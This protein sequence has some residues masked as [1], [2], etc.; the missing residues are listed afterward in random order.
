LEFG[1]GIRD[2]KCLDDGATRCR[3]SFKIGL[4]VLIQYRPWRTDGQTDGR[5]RCRSLYALCYR[6]AQ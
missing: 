6:V 2:P 4:V 1:I 3:K 5:T